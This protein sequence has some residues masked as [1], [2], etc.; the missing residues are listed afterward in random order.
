MIAEL[1]PGP[2][3]L[4]GRT[5]AAYIGRMITAREREAWMLER[6]VAAAQGM[7][8]TASDRRE[9]NVFRVASMIVRPRFPRQAES[10]LQAS[11]RY[12]AAHPGDKLGTQDVIRHGWTPGLPRM[13]EMLSARLKSDR[14]S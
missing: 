3:S 14:T 6:C 11:D 5:T 4:A 8:D 2:P 9:A 7:V 10:L 1:A 13:R 12:F